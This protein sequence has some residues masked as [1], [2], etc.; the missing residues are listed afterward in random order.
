MTR[1][2]VGTIL[3]VQSN[4]SVVVDFG[5]WTQVCNPYFDLSLYEEDPMDESQENPNPQE[6][7]PEEPSREEMIL[8]QLRIRA[9]AGEEIRTRFDDFW[10]NTQGRIEQNLRE[11]LGVTDDRQIEQLLNLSKGVA[12]MTWASHL[13][14]LAASFEQMATMEMAVVQVLGEVAAQ[15]NQEDEGGEEAP[16]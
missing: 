14:I 6:S 10:E 7:P 2:P 4:G 8:Q 5:R 13:G 1:T 3:A 9:A 12:R 16:E 11:S 15:K